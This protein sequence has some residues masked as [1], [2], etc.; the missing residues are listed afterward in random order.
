MSVNLLI[1]TH[2]E[3]GDALVK[4]ASSALGGMP[5]PTTVVTVSY[6][7]DP[8]ELLKKLKQVSC[9]L[10]QGDD[11]LLVLTDL[12]GSTPSNI[13]A[14]LQENNRIR[15]IAG[16]NLP[17]LIRIMNYSQLPLEELAEKALSGGKDGVINC[18]KNYA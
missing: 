8:D 6:D 17:M 15:V 11:G 16:L 4:A 5:L 3:I 7:T 12:Y 9:N 1:I 18:S 14:S 10:L 13:A 2:E